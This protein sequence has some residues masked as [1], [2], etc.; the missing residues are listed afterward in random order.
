MQIKLHLVSMPWANPELPSIQTAVL[1][2]YIDSVLGEKI[3]T[4][5]YS[6]FASILLEQNHGGYADYYDKYQ[7][8]EEYPYFLMYYRRFLRHDSSLRQVSADKLIQRINACDTDEPLTLRKL[9]HLERRTHRY[10]KEVIVP[11]LS[12]RGLNVMGFT[13]NYYQLY[14]S[15]YCARYL[16]EHFPNYKYLFVFGGATVIYPKVAEVLRV[17]DVEGLCVIGE[18]ERKLELILREILAIP[19]KDSAGLVERVA[20]LHEGIYDIQHRTVNLY[21]PT[22]ATLLDL[23]TPMDSLPQPNFSEYYAALRKV[24]TDRKLHAEYKAETWLTLEGTRGCF[25]HCDFCDV[26]TSWSGFRKSTPERILANVLELATKHRSP[27][28]KF[29]DN[30]CD[31]W[32]ERYSELLIE[33]KIRIASFMECRV[34]HPETF[35]TKLSLSGVELVQVGIEAFSPE[36]I[37]AMNKGTRAKQN[38][39]VQKWLKELGIESLSNLISHH[40]KST[41]RHVDETKHVLRL[42]PH[43]DRLDF[44][45]LGLLIGSPLDGRLS[46]EEKSQLEERQLFELPKRLD[47]YFVL[48]GEYQP[49]DNW[50]DAGVFD[51]WDKLIE[52]EEKFYRNC[53]QDAFMS[54]TR[55]GSEEILIRDG[56]YDEI[57]EYHLLGDTA[58][59]YNLCHQGATLQTLSRDTGLP[60]TT[61]EKILSW[62]VG[63]Q[64]AVE[65]DEFYIALAL[66]PRDELIHNYVEATIPRSSSPTKV[67][68]F[69]LPLYPVTKTAGANQ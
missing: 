60:S 62:L 67:K 47:R 24:F 44:S 3:V 46:P 68:E 13:L 22:P 23:Q 1:K 14:A 31:T 32:A 56:R 11:Q 26:H 65:L 6:A 48:K 38:L 8:F 64:L 37:R 63:K 35:W 49:P 4:R 5:T 43:L 25:A 16:Q 10:I 39:L 55:Y 36:L 42:I 34:H 28:V 12:R 9:A 27:R 18:G 54:S 66:R 30:V 50:F 41:L 58:R 53:G 2:A 15:L 21:E 19:S 7:D 52:W 33:R 45:P 20:A 29:M 59:I 17:L 40:P 57:K 61:I 69:A 51:A